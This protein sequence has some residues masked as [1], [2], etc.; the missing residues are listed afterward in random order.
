M[1]I[2]ALDFPNADEVKAFIPKLEG[3]VEWVKVGMELFYS[4]GPAIVDYLQAQG[5][6][7]FLDLKLHDIPNT[8]SSS[9][10]V[11]DTM[12]VG[13]VNVHALGGIDMLS[14]AREVVRDTLLIGVTILTSHNDQAISQLNLK[15]NVFENVLNL[16]TLSDECGL[17]GIVCSGQDLKGMKDKLREKF[18]FVTPGIRLNSGSQDQK[19]IMTPG[20]AMRAGATHLVIGREITK[21]NDVGASI[22]AIKKDIDDSLIA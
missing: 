20:Q 19:R 21:A 14:K 5:Y 15:G 8:V 1:I 12:G 2:V 11:I 4:E 13:M 9:L 18:L 16:A 7:V 22:A 17:D 10:K 6:K 3:Q